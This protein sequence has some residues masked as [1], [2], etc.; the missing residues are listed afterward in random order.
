MMN[1]VF[2]GHMTDQALNY[3]RFWILELRYENDLKNYRSFLPSLDFPGK[4]VIFIG[5][6]WKRE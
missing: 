4:Y 5:D 2:G 1:F 3:A 6:F